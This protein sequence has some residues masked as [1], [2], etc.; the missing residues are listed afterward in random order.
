M[1]RLTIHFLKLFEN[2]IGIVLV[3]LFIVNEIRPLSDIMTYSTSINITP[4]SQANTAI[5]LGLFS[6]FAFSL[7]LP[8]SKIAVQVLTG[9][10]VGLL[11]SLIGG[12]MAM[13]I[14]LIKHCALP[15]R[16]QIIRLYLGSLGII[17]GFPIF[18]SLA[19]KTV[20]VSH[21]AIVLAILPLST[22]MFGVRLS[23]KVMPLAFWIWSTVGALLVI[24]YVV[25][26][27]DLQSLVLGDIYLAL[28][29]I[30][31]GFGYAQSGQL[32]QSMPGWQVICWML[33]L[34][35]P[36]ILG[37]S[38]AFV[39]FSHI[40]MMKASHI[41]ALLFLASVS[42]L[43]GFF[44]WNKAL[45]MGGIATISQLQLLQTFLTYGVAVLFMGE[46]WNWLS[47]IICLLV[48][49]TVYQTQKTARQVS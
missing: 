4:D 26:T 35:F 25:M 32:S 6:V 46:Q 39:D 44:S 19:M 21:G 34:N 36:I 15:N 3:N 5:L 48:V 31:A 14:L 17:Y 12:V 23:K 41:G 20:P 18:S 29:V 40:N 13:I 27:K 10:E 42:G 1:A 22:A 11:R 24:G 45:A 7:T 38:L 16:Q 30:L 47:S 9:L 49:A 33:V 28:A 43:F 2:H 8:F 37:L